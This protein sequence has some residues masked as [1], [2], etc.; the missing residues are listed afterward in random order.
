VLA[1]APAHVRLLSRLPAG[2]SV[3][4]QLGRL[5]VRRGVLVELAAHARVEALDDHKLA[6]LRHHDRV[7][8]VTTGVGT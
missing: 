8:P 2:L 3:P 1:V 5:Q 7:V 4:E 6:A